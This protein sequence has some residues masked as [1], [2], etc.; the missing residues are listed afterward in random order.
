MRQADNTCRWCKKSFQSERTLI[1]HMCP[2]KRRWGDKDMT[3]ARLG[4]RVYQKFYEI[5]INSDKVKTV[6]DFI[7]SSYYEGFVKFG[8]ACVRNEYLEPEKFAEWLIT[9]GIKLK[10]W[11]ADAT[12]N[13]FL[14]EYVKKEPGIRAMER[15]IVYLSKWQDESEQPWSSYFK[16]VSTPRAVHDIKA[17]K[18]SPW[19]LYLSDSGAE[20][21][22]RL[23]DEQVKMIYPIIDTQFWMTV[24]SKN[25]EET[26]IVKETCQ[27][28]GI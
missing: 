16:E 5:S 25:K 19:A 14:R 13:D 20:L 18:I 1:A 15:T 4:F 22:S 7:E 17:A 24:F 21:L 10:D 11:G 23:S 26:R 9:K 6:E 28:A 2:K 12:Y 27:A 8:R 3:H